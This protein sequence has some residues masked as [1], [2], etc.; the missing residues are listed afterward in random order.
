MK[1]ICEIPG[2]EDVM[3]IYYIGKCGTVYSYGNYGSTTKG[4]RRIKK[5][6]PKTGG[7][8]YAYLMKIGGKMSTLRLHRIVASAYVKNE[9]S[10]PHV[11][12]IDGNRQ[13]N[14]YKN[15]EWVTPKENNDHSLTKKIFCYDTSGN[16]KKIYFGGVEAEADGYNQG[17]L[18]AVARGEEKTH[19]KRVFSYTFKTKEEIVQRLSKTFPRKKPKGKSE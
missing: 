4:K 2:Y 13:N 1:K 15:L 14:N 5:S 3:P 18:F 8:M 11:N 10:K 12:H 7:Y 9:E 17:H 6:V 19:K 16:L